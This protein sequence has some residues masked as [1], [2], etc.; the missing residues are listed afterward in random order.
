[1]LCQSKVPTETMIITATRAAIGISADHV[2]QP[3]DEDQQERPGQERREPGA[4]AR[5]P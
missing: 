5:T 2:A 4:G 3:D 1:M